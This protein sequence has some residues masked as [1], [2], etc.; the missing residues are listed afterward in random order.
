M[1]KYSVPLISKQVDSNVSTVLLYKRSLR[2]E[3]PF[4]L[5]LSLSPLSL[6]PPLSRYMLVCAEKTL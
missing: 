3:A 1:K 2:R 5:S 4:S 6:S